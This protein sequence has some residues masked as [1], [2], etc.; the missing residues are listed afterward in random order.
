[1]N[2]GLRRKLKQNSVDKKRLKLSK[3]ILWLV[4]CVFFRFLFISCYSIF[5]SSIASYCKTVTSTHLFML[6]YNGT[7]FVIQKVAG[8]LFIRQFVG[9]CMRTLSQRRATIVNKKCSSWERQATTVLLC[10]FFF[11]HNFVLFMDL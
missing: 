4:N 10:D 6:L 3:S 11:A 2:D 7:N 9:F 8:T 1:M 5:R